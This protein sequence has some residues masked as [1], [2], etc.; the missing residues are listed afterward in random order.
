MKESLWNLTTTLGTSRSQ[1]KVLYLSL[2]GNCT[3]RKGE[4]SSFMFIELK[5]FITFRRLMV[6][7]RKLL[8]EGWKSVGIAKFKRMASAVEVK[9]T[10]VIICYPPQWKVGTVCE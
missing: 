4:Y 9:D 7:E 10:N 1:T 5:L 6:I 3:D 2:T 8:T